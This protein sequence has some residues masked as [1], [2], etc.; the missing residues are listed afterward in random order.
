V[1]QDNRKG[2]P[3]LKPQESTFYNLGLVSNTKYIDVE[4]SGYLERVKNLFGL[5]RGVWQNAGGKTKIHGYTIS[6]TIRPIDGLSIMGS[7]TNQ[8]YRLE[9]QQG[10]SVDFATYLPRSFAKF[11][12]Y[13][14][15][16]VG[17][18]SWGMG[19][20]NTW[21][22]DSFVSLTYRDGTNASFL[23]KSGNFWLTD[24][25]IYFKPTEKIRVTLTL[26][27]VFD[28]REDGY[29]FGTKAD[30]SMERNTYIYSEPLGQPFTAS[31]GISYSF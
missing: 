30:P 8:R 24:A 28:A 31:L 17:D 21:V 14:D 16:K 6:T 3:N 9:P 7:Y 10:P 25:S 15:G 18:Y 13:W 1:N 5:A 27:N 12:L 20:Y 19:I 11:N 23:Y 29:S 2:N 22:G 26:T 4:L